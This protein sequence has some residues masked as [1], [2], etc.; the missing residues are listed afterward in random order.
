MSWSNNGVGFRPTNPM[1]A[2]PVWRSRRKPPKLCERLLGRWD[3]VTVKVGQIVRSLKNTSD[4]SDE[5]TMG[6]IK[7]ATPRILGG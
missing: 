1:P 4:N 7:K 2:E 6:S 3:G 5:A